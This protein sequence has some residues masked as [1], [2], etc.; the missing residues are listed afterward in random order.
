M[1]LGLGLGLERDRIRHERAPLY[2]AL[3]VV[4]VDPL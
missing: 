2:V 4:A 1:G 3:T